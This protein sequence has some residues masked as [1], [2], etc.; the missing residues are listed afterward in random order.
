[1]QRTFTISLQNRYTA[2][3]GVYNE[4]DATQCYA[5]FIQANK[6]T[7]ENLKPKKKHTRN[8]EPSDDHRVVLARNDVHDAF[9][10]F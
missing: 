3:C 9:K 2:L 4:I 8:K 5:Y 6:E 7:A 1:M 10:N